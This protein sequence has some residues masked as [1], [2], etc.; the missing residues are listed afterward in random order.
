[1]HYRYLLPLMGF[2]FVFTTGAS[3]IDKETK[4][5]VVSI[6]SRMSGISRQ[7]MSHHAEAMRL[8]KEQRDQLQI[9]IQRVDALQRQTS[10]ALAATAIP[11]APA[12]AVSAEESQKAPAE[13]VEVPAPAQQTGENPAAAHFSRTQKIDEMEEDNMNLETIM[14]QPIKI[15]QKEYRN[16]LK[17]FKFE[18]EDYKLIRN[19]IKTN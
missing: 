2:L 17:E 6:E 18:R 12:I 9:L 14:K 8:L 1:M 11:P 19:E 16:C 3:F 5:R 4:A 10:P 13:P 15:N 7:E